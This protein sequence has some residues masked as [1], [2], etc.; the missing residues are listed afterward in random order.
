MTSVRKGVTPTK[1]STAQS[2]P[3]SILLPSDFHAM[4]RLELAQE[5]SYLLTTVQER[6][7]ASIG[8][9]PTSLGG[10]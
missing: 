6:L 8:E 4:K 10:S 2:G 7:Q 3:G 9:P 1:V 5:D